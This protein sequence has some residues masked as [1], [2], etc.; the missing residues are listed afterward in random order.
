MGKVVDEKTGIVTENAIRIVVISEI[1]V[2]SC[3]TLSSEL[4][5]FPIRVDS[6]RRHMQVAEGKLA[7]RNPL[8]QTEIINDQSL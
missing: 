3:R 2:K 8:D 4:E 7:V 5:S 1:C 6:R